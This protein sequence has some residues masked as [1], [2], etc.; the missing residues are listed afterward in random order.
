MPSRNF[1]DY[2]GN[3]ILEGKAIYTAST[4]LMEP[5]RDVHG[6]GRQVLL[7]P[8]RHDY[9]D[10]NTSSDMIDADCVV[11]LLLVIR[12]LKGGKL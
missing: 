8:G 12:E 3:E 9:A 1:C 10:V 4:A 11:K 2:C 7:T 6:Q 5:G